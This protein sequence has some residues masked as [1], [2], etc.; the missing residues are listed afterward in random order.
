M[1]ELCLSDSLCKNH[2][3]E[4][5]FAISAGNQLEYEYDIAHWLMDKSCFYL[6]RRVKDAD[7]SKKDGLKFQD[8]II[9]V[10]SNPQLV[11]RASLA[12]MCAQTHACSHLFYAHPFVLSMLKLILSCMT[13]NRWE[14]S[15]PL[16]C[17][18]VN[19]TKIRVPMQNHNLRAC[20]CATIIR[21]TLQ[22]L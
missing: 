2:C 18:T 1:M 4:R 21:L 12:Q 7:V 13:S 20:T 6:P 16:P 10:W 11:Y 8:R 22:P 17:L 9:W 5:C 14:K 19:S 15:D 3:R